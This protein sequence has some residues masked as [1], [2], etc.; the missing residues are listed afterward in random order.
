[1]DTQYHVITLDP[2]YEEGDEVDYEIQLVTDKGE[3]EVDVTTVTT[4]TA[5][6][7]PIPTDVFETPLRDGPFTASEKAVAAHAAE[8][9]GFTLGRRLETGSG[10]HD[11]EAHL[12]PSMEDLMHLIVY[13]HPR[14]S[15]LVVLRGRGRDWFRVRYDG[16]VVFSTT[17]ESGAIVEAD[18]FADRLVT[19]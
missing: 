14:V 8:H 9:H 19:P 16:D 2:G 12:E 13:R 10:A 6:L 17:S 15:D 7:G 3:G 18:D 4:D 5:T 1:M 11:Y